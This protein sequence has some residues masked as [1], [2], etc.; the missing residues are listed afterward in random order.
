MNEITRANQLR[1]RAGHLRDL[2]DELEASPVMRLDRHGDI[3]TWRGPR[4]DLCRATLAANQHQMHAAADNLRWHA[5]RFE[6]Q[7]IELEAT[8][9]T[10][11]GLAG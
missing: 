4:P 8:A 10:R 2:A 9:R 5:Y 3:D 6:Q 1:R 11:I 7:A